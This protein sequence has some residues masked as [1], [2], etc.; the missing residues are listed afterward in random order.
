MIAPLKVRKNTLA[1]LFLLP[2]HCGDQF[3]PRTTLRALSYSA[4]GDLPKLSV[5]VQNALRSAA[6]GVKL[7]ELPVLTG[8]RDSASQGRER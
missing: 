3:G 6:R 1:Q 2:G 8:N 4:D 7:D 5:S